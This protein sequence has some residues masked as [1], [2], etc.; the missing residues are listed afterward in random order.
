VRK[1]AIAV[2]LFGGVGARWVMIG[3][4][5]SSK[6]IE[7]RSSGRSLSWCEL[8]IWKSDDGGSKRDP[9]RFYRHG[10]GRRQQSLA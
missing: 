8:F 2:G 5:K 1:K 3:I 7:R 4:A 6:K 9:W 10:F